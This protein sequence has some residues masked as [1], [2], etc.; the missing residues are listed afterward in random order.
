LS[1]TA[2]QTTVPQFKFSQENNSE[3]ARRTQT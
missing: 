3:R 1:Q 2:N